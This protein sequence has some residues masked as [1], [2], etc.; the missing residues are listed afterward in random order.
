MG[1]TVVNWSVDV[2]IGLPPLNRDVNV[3]V[4]QNVNVSLSNR[5]HQQGRVKQ[6]NYPKPSLKSRVTFEVENPWHFIETA[7]I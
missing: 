6:T 5:T 3:F 1:T 7:D 4:Y 2:T